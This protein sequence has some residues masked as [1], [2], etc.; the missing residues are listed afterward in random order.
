M[1]CGTGDV[2]SGMPVCQST[3]AHVSRWFACEKAYNADEVA[4]HGINVVRS[5]LALP[6]PDALKAM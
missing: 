5:L 1:L 6:T 2:L 3:I 4:R